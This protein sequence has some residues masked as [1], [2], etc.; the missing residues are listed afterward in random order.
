MNGSEINDQNY[1]NVPGT[2]YYS[3]DYPQ[4]IS[5]NSLPSLPLP[6]N[7]VILS[8]SNINLT[9]YS[10]KIN[11]KTVECNEN[12]N[13]L[14]TDLINGAT[15]SCAVTTWADMVKRSG[16]CSLGE[17]RFCT[18]SNLLPNKTNM[19]IGV[20]NVSLNKQNNENNTEHNNNELK[21]FYF[22][23]IN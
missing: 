2:I 22:F 17:T 1:L 12:N 3:Q 13:R 5:I 19:E 7:Q 4:T 14:N 9:N 8:E 21:F 18:T 6:N 11:A 15:T 16:N 10:N 20:E 23:K